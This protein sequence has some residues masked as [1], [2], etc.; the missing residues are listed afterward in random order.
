[1]LIVQI[2]LALLIIIVILLQGKSGGLGQTF[3]GSSESFRTKRG[4]E[5]TLF[6]LTIILLLAFLITSILSLR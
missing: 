6:Y 2:A 5:K 3:A 4:L 1:M